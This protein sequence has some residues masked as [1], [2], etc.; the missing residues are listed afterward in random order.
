MSENEQKTGTCT[1]E[2]QPGRLKKTIVMVGMM[3]AGKTAVGRALAARLQVP[4]LDS[5]HEIESASN[6]YECLEKAPIFKPDIILLDLMMPGMSGIETLQHL[7]KDE[8]LRSIPVIMISANDGDDTIVDALDLGAQDYVTKP[9]IYPVLEARLRS[10][11]RLKESQEKLEEANRTLEQLASLD[12][13]T[14]LYNHR[15]FFN[16]AGAEFAKARRHKRPIST[17]MIDADHFKSINDSHGHAMGD[18]ALISLSR[19]CE[20]LIR[21]SDFIGRLGGEEFAVC[22][23]DTDQDGATHLA[24]RI[25]EAISETTVEHEGETL[26]FTVSIGVATMCDHDGSFNSVLDRAD[27]LLYRAKQ[28]GRNRVINIADA[29]MA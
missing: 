6:G 12:P 16:L 19:T 3:G 22:C 28:T 25:R 24:E 10:A 21:E 29:S 11:V 1:V 8:S 9:F 5:D 13:L 17:I 7:K 14:E 23:P 2:P 4:F 15:H 27:N 20:K 18:Q 26:N